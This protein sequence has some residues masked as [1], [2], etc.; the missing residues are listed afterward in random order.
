MTIKTWEYIHR[1]LVEEESKTREVYRAARRL[2]HEY[3]ESE[4]AD[5][6]LVQ[7]QKKAADEYMKKNFAAKDALYE[8]E[9]KEW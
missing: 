7:R 8:F 5:E 9:K 1:L 6:D 4:T 2:Q 3:E